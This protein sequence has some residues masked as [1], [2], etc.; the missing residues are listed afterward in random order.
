M[1]VHK[2]MMSILVEFNCKKQNPEETMLESILKVTCK[3]ASLRKGRI[4]RPW[5]AAK[6]NAL[7]FLSQS[8]I[9][10]AHKK[11]LEMLCILL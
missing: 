10:C 3:P 6:E 2:E 8:E 5:W 11:I 4:A 9:L 7:E 1:K